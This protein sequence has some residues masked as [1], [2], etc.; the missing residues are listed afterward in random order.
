MFLR[1]FCWGV[2]E[3]GGVGAQGVD[4]AGRLVAGELDGGLDVLADHTGEVGQAG[5]AAFV[6][7]GVAG[8]SG[9]AERGEQGA[10][11]GGADL[12]TGVGGLLLDDLGVDDLAV[13]GV[14]C[15]GVLRAGGLLPLCAVR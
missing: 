10:L 3:V 9:V 12:L 5:G 11:L 4:A 13:S 1:G 15:R 8:E 6:G 7:A 2:G 14:V